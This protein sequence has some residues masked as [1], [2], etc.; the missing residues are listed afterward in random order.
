LNIF[1]ETNIKTTSLLATSIH[2][3][4]V[5]IAYFEAPQDQ[6]DWVPPV[7]LKKTLVSA[8]VTILPPDHTQFVVR[9]SWAAKPLN[10]IRLVAGT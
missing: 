1:V 9:L 4:T 6:S 2:L 3:H 10:F 8:Y 5:Y 7:L